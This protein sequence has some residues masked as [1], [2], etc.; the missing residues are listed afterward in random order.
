MFFHRLRW[1]AQGKAESRMADLGTAA[2]TDDE[3]RNGHRPAPGGA[4]GGR[5]GRT[6]NRPVPGGRAV[7][8]GFLVA[9]A[10]VGL[11]WAST[12]ESAPSDRYVV[13]TRAVAPGARL[14]AADL[15]MVPLDLPAT[16]SQR[17]FRDVAALE[18]STAIGPLGA[19]ELVQASAV[20]AKP[21]AQASREVSF[22]VPAATLGPG[23][24][25][26]ERID[27]IATFAGGDAFSTVVLRQALVVGL[28][29]DQRD[30]REVTVTV[31]VD[32]PAD[33]VA[34]AHA[35]QEGKLTVVR[36]TGA[37]PLPPHAPVFRGSASGASGR[38]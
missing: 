33:A 2:R 28:D 10:V 8:G 25:T 24:E 35:N 18:G 20:V 7:L 12:R 37:T 11:F 27:V 17:A 38:S 29:R 36:A 9:A 13:T 14:T 22:V 1:K 30:E 19:G 5:N 15:A 31:A 34:L 4:S 26:G 21:S 23:L 32:D 16:L 6:G 3:R